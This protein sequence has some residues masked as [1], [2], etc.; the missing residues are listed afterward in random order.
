MHVVVWAVQPPLRV[1]MCHLVASKKQFLEQFSLY[2]HG[3]KTP[4]FDIMPMAGSF[5]VIPLD[6]DWESC[7]SY[8][9]REGFCRD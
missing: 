3:W 8:F 6:P 4:V 1:G 2:Q 7:T 9:L 5:L